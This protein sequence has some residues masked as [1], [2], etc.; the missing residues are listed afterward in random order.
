M[1]KWLLVLPSERGLNVTCLSTRNP[2]RFTL[3]LPSLFLTWRCTAR[4]REVFSN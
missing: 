4:L 2:E 3:Q 1:P